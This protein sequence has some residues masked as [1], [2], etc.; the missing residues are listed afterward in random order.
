MKRSVKL[1]NRMLVVVMIWTSVFAA[2]YFAVQHASAK[3]SIANVFAATGVTATANGYVSEEFAPSHTI[4]GNLNAGKW[5]YEGGSNLPTPENPYWLKI[6]AGTEVNVQQFVLAHAGAAGE[7]EQYNTKDFTIEASS[8]NTNW[9]NVVT[10]TGNTAGT[11]THDLDKPVTAR[12]FKLNIT[13]PGDADPSTGLFAAHIYEFQ[14]FGTVEEPEEQPETE[15]VAATAGNSTPG[16]LGQ[17]YLGNSDFSFG[18]YK[19]TSIDPQLNFTDLTPILKNMTGAE[20]FVN[21]RWTGQI[22]PPADGD[23]TFYMMGDNGFRLWIDNKLAIDHWVDDWDKEQ[24]S[25]PITLQGN[26]KYDFKVEY[27]EH[28]GGSNLFLRWSTPT[29]TKDIV[30]SNAFSLPADYTGVAAGI[31]P[32]DGK[33]VSMTMT[34]G[35]KPVSADV[36]AHLILKVDDQPVSVQSVTAGANAANFILNLSKAILPGQRVSIA[37]DGLGALQYEDGTAVTGFMFTPANLSEITDYS[38]IAI[39][40][41]LYGSAKTNR[42]F[43]WYTKYDKP[44]S[45]PVNITDS[46]VEVVPAGKAFGSD[47]TIRFVGKPEE[48]RILN[49]KVTSNVN[50]SFISHKVLVDGLTPATAY[51]YRVGSD[52]NWSQTGSF[53]TEAEDVKNFNFLYMTDSQGGNSQDYEV[54]ANTMRQATQHVTDPKFLLMTGDQVDAGA[55][56]SQWLDYFGKPQ[57]MLMNLPIMAAVGN[58]EGPYNDNYYYHFNY[59]NNSIANPLP[60]GSVY[61]YDYGDAHIMVLN[62]MDI[63]WDDA[64]KKAF[65]QEVDWLKRE[66]AETDKKW[67]VVAFHKAIYSVG[68][69]ALDSDILALRQRMYP[70]FDELGIDVVLQGHDHTFMRSYQMYNNQAIKDVEK[71]GDGRVLNPDGTLY[72]INNSAATKFYDVKDNVDRYYAAVYQQPKVAIYSGVKM[73]ENSFTIDSYKSGEETPFDT[74]SIVRNDVKPNPVEQLKTDKTED[75]KRTLTWKK[76]QDDA[77]N[78]IRGFRIYEA[79]GKLGSNWSVYMPVTAGQENYEYVTPATNPDQAYTFIVKA[80]N[81]RDN[82]A[83][84]T[85]TSAGSQPAAPTAPVEDDAHNTFGWANVPG[86]AV[87]SDYEYSL[88]NGE[89]WLPVTANPQPIEDGDYDAGT[90]QVRIKAHEDLGIAAGKALVSTKAFTK[91]DTRDT[92]LLSGSISRGDQLKVNVNVEPLIAYSDDAFVVFQLLKGNNPEPVLISAVPLKQTKLTM[93]QYFNEIGEEYKVKVFI[94]NQFNSKLITPVQLARPI[95]FK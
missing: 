47:A 1:T 30:P 78:A 62:T 95:L 52:G 8:D 89:T 2:G 23:Y 26:H 38:P 43:A 86:Y 71:D 76:P 90:V 29:L 14:A 39:A 18:D 37:Y 3:T 84:S 42:S 57:D 66:V 60:P 81:K 40:M 55:L 54:W 56:E 70:I 75:G 85:V 19:G 4:D 21:A 33:S 7:Q 83:A 82:S 68:N 13:N 51:Q 61:A 45:A 67:K 44:Q 17:Y 74:Y 92:F 48:T 36:N 63:G 28:N 50:G 9:Q 12:Y 94:V 93:T 72:M 58:H 22:M 91:N 25:S 10:V 77:T 69:H 73:T 6:D 15:N 31:V 20:D 5:V 16:L 35:L 49:L 27:F 34:S 87:L 32:A 80:V 53:T 46:I 88:N 65:D 11:T 64:Q 59:P 79:N 41:S 24:T